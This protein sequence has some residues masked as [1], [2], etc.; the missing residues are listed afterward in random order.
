MLRDDVGTH[1]CDGIYACV[2]LAAALPAYHAQHVAPAME[3]KQ[4]VPKGSPLAVPL[5]EGEW[6]QQRNS[7]SDAHRTRRSE[8][9]TCS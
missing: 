8:R 7:G 9:V 2:L 1:V 5:L 4:A 3:Y 6:Q